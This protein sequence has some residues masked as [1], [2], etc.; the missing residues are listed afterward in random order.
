M[1]KKFIVGFVVQ[2][3]NDNGDLVSQEFVGGDDVTYE[4]ENGDIIDPPTNESRFPM[5]MMQPESAK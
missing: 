1:F 5:M 2:E 4:D 3:F